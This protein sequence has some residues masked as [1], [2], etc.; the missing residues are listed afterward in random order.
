M[1]GKLGI[2]GVFITCIWVP[3]LFS[4]YYVIELW[5]VISVGMLFTD[6]KL[7]HQISSITLLTMHNLI[8]SSLSLT[9]TFKQ[10]MRHEPP[11]S[12]IMFPNDA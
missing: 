9:T 5:V 1:I 8:I 12:L 10:V 4:G 11:Q 6:V 2:L 7:T 3:C